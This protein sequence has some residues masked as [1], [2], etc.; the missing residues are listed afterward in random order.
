MKIIGRLLLGLCTLFGAHCS[1]VKNENQRGLAGK[2]IESVGNGDAVVE[3]AANPDGQAVV[4]DG[5][6]L[7]PLKV[8]S[9]VDVSAMPEGFLDDISHISKISPTRTLLY[10]KSGFSWLMDEE[11]LGV[12]SKLQT[13]VSI[14]A[15]SR[16]FVQEGQHFWLF[17]ASSIAFPS[18]KASEDLGQV[19]L[20]NVTPEL[21]KDPQHKVLYVGPNSVILGSEAKA[22]ILIRDGD[23]VRAINLDL[24]KQSGQVV[25][26]TA[27][28]QAEGAD[29]FWF[30]TNEQLLLLKRGQGGQFQWRVAKF[31]VD[32]GVAGTPGQVAMLLAAP[33][34]KEITF[35][36]RTFVL[37]AGKLYEKEALKLSLPDEKAAAI[38]QNFVTNVQPL[39]KNNCVG[40]HPG[41]DT[42][43]SATDKA[44]AYKTHLMNKTMPPAP[45]ALSDA[46]TKIILDWY[47]SIPL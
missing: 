2:N 33:N 28:G 22:N 17:G 45:N 15:G 46:D 8:G 44:A 19:S 6:D 30:L 7:P 13:N 31:K 27:A 1:K 11:K 3:D 14:P 43:Q 47:A 39:L 38:A 40:C 26:V 18:S 12:L 20:L 41:Y 16:M 34:E 24:P 25:T 29:A 42:Q 10:S 37:N 5:S 35:L 4:T 23:K 32:P 36:G 21:L 9:E